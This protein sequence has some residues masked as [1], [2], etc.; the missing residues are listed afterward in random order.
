ML[1]V[2]VEQLLFVLWLFILLLVVNYLCPPD[3]SVSVGRF[4]VST[5][6]LI[7]VALVTGL[8]FLLVHFYLT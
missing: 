1:D 2:Y 4:I 8:G 5:L 3:K 7:L 6:L